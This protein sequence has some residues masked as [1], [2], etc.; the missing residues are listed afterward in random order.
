MIRNS[1]PLLGTKVVYCNPMIG[2]PEDQP[3]D[4]PYYWAAKALKFRLTGYDKRYLT[5]YKP[6]RFAK[7]DKILWDVEKR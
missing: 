7:M 2:H 4:S 3:V 6:R 1:I 5:K